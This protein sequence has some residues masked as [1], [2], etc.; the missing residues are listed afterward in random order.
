MV[1]RA[2]TDSNSSIERQSV[3]SVIQ[4]QERK[5]IYTAKF[6]IYVIPPLVDDGVVPR[7]KFCSFTHRDSI[8]KIL[9][10]LPSLY[11]KEKNL[12][13]ISSLCNA[14]SNL[15]ALEESSH[16]GI[17]RTDSEIFILVLSA[18]AILHELAFGLM[19]LPM[20]LMATLSEQSLQA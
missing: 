6:W 8:W 16:P 11:Q 2:A 13:G 1:L 20:N 10:V 12:H 3:D 17:L 5:S 18:Q 14:V 4:I 15:D 9:W 7:V 19:A